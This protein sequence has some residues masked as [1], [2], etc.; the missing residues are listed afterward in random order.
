[1]CW[2]RAPGEDGAQA[3]APVPALDPASE[4]ELPAAGPSV[5]DQLARRRQV[6]R[7]TTMFAGDARWWHLVLSSL[8]LREQRQLYGQVAGSY[9]ARCAPA[10][11]FYEEPHRPHPVPWGLRGRALYGRP[12]QSGAPY[13]CGARTTSGR[14][15]GG[16]RDLDADPVPD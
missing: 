13:V 6:E 12:P 8:P 5:F 2:S 10:G 9:P 14:K 16:H 11:G 4:V 15:S 1:M 7:P 3:P